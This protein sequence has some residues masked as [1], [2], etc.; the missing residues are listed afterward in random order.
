MKDSSG[1]KVNV[2]FIC[3]YKGHLPGG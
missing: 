3:W 1:E 2:A